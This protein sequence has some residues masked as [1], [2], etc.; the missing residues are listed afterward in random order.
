MLVGVQE[1]LTDVTV[2]DSDGV[3]LIDPPQ[4]ISNKKPKNERTN[5]ALRVMAFPVKSNHPWGSLVTVTIGYRRCNSL[6]VILI[7]LCGSKNRLLSEVFY[8]ETPFLAPFHGIVSFRWSV[9][10][11]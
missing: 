1:K 7:T 2:C 4:P 9:S 8:P 6:K 11:S 5:R 10:P 3:K